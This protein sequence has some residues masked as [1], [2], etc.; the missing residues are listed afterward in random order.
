MRNKELHDQWKKEESQPFHGWDF[1]RMEGRIHSED[2]PWDYETI[3]RNLLKRDHR[4]LD[5][6]TGG[7][8]FLLTLGHPYEKTSVTEAYEPNI[9]LCQERLSPLGITV[10]PIQDDDL[11]AIPDGAFDVVIN[12]HESYDEAQVWRILSEGGWFITQQVGATNNQELARRFDPHRSDPF[13]DMTLKRCVR[14]L[15]TQGF[16]IQ[17][18]EEAF[19][20]TR[21]HDI[22]ALVYTAKVLPWEFPSFFVDR[23]FD[24]LIQLEQERRQTGWVSSR[25]HRLLIVA[26][27]PSPSVDPGDAP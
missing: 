13:P 15:R 27:K 21:Y 1:S 9:R 24:V 2:L 18:Q 23:C 19:P 10:H 22:G 16:L 3:V 12:R 8:E 14:R 20:I 17:R 7:G 4:L 25:E 6:G 26:Q 5:M 11:R